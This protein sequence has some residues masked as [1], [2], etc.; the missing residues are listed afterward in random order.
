MVNC[1]DIHVALNP[2][3]FTR[4]QCAKNCLKTGSLL[5]K[6]VQC[7]TAGMYSRNLLIPARNFQAS[8]WR[9]IQRKLIQR[10]MLIK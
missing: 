1:E 8:L 9:K 4:A 5:S 3:N 6:F 10:V 7:A 2:S